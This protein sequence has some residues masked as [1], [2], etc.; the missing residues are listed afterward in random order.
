MES[1]QYGQYTVPDSEVCVNFGAGQPCSK[2]LPLDC[3]N[4]ALK[5]LTKNT[6]NSLL[7]YGAIKGYSNFRTILAEFL[8]PFYSNTYVDPEE[9]L[10]TQGV[11]GALTLLLS[12]LVKDYSKC[13]IF[14][15]DPTY[16]L[17]LN[18]FK[19]FKL[20]VECIDMQS[21]G[22]NTNTLDMKLKEYTEKF[23]DYQFFLYTI[24]VYNNPTGITMSNEKRLKLKQIA[25]KYPNFVVFADEVYQLLNFSTE[26]EEYMPLAYWHDNF[27]S[28]GSMSKIFAPAVRLGWIQADKK[29][30]TELENSGQLDSGGCVNPIGCAI[31][32]QI[33]KNG[34]LY[35]VK[36]FW[37]DFL[38]RNCNKL[39]DCLME[40]FGDEIEIVKPKGGYFLWCKLKYNFYSMETISKKMEDYKVK[41]HY[42]NKFSSSKMYGS[43]FRLSFSWYENEDIKIGVSRLKELFDSF[44]KKQVKILGHT[45]KLGKLIIKELEKNDKLTFAGGIGRDIDIQD[46][47][48]VNS[49]IIDVSRPEATRKLLEKLIEE[50]KTIP[51]I[52][53]TTGDLPMDLIEEY[54]KMAIVAI[55]SNFSK[56]IEQMKKIINSI[57]KSMWNASIKEIHHIHKVDKPSGTAKTLAHEY[58]NIE[59]EKIISIR[60]GENYGTHELLL[61]SDSEQIIITHIA[62]S[63]NLFAEGAIRW[64][65]YFI[66]LDDFN[67]LYNHI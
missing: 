5:E 18:I 42:G 29:F 21:D 11:T 25:N 16:F 55:S 52:I 38:E 44:N 47:F 30:I 24:P 41:F 60:E 58:G 17:A 26:E 49:I 28:I 33:I 13:I 57:D 48:S 20:K 9:L 27:I 63:R 8:Q 10:I 59:N 56:G 15:E 7:Q 6:N 35:L 19:D 51:L 50:N 32:E 34:S 2:Y 62:K 4:N 1:I 67:G 66:E 65:E 39:Y 53:G 37:Q 61:D 40:T 12:T 45:G 14:C 43:Y 54:S 31:M 22:L 23:P 64:L 3:F 46:L 36:E